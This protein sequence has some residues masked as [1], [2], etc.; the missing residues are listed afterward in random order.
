MAI[1]GLIR[2]GSVCKMSNSLLV[3]LDHHHRA[4]VRACVVASAYLTTS[5]V[6]LLAVYVLR[7]L[8]PSHEA[9]IVLGFFFLASTISGLAPATVKAA[10]L[11]G[12]IRPP[13]LYPLLAACAAKA[14]LAVP[15]LAVVWRFA[16]PS[17]PWALVFW[18]PLVCM[19]GFGA[20]DLRALLDLR[21]R[22]A[23][24]I[25]LKQGS[26]AGGLGL[27]TLLI[28]AGVSP[29]W[30]IGISTLVRLAPLLALGWRLGRSSGEPARPLWD[31][32]LIS[33]GRWLELSGASV[34]AAISGSTDRVLGL[35]FLPAAAW[36]TY[37]LIYEIGS[38]FWFVP[39]LISPI[40]FARRVG[41]ATSVTFI[42]KAWALTAGLGLVFLIG[43]AALLTL[44]P[45]LK[46]PVVGGTPSLTIFAFG[47]A[48]VLASFTQIRIAE[49]QGAGRARLATRI[50]AFSAAVSSIAFFIG[51]AAF[52]APGL[53][54]G[55]LVKSLVDFA[56]AMLGGRRGFGGRHRG[57]E[58]A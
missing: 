27:L 7:R 47:T 42:R 31:P 29:F 3:P 1:Y 14:L 51:V 37:Y 8:A 54:V 58:A 48:V 35:H 15:V 33:D 2:A 52:G 56:A 11:K 21:G 45:S 13:D 19:A 10:A 20:T 50:I 28:L 4:V 9:Q 16:D 43:V 38:K 36:A 25:W 26:L 55:W 49:L 23:A 32:G 6:V 24:A 34:I 41:Q 18:L 57:C 39:Y 12:L 5:A 40:V 46:T 22:Y 17:A 53:L 44:P 30:A